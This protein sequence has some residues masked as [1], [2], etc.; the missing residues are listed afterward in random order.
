[1]KINQSKKSKFLK[2]KY[3][4]SDDEIKDFDDYKNQ[5]P[6]SSESDSNNDK[7]GNDEISKL[8][9][10]RKEME[11]LNGDDI[12]TIEDEQDEA[13]RSMKLMLK[14]GIIPDATMI[15]QARKKR[16]MARQGDYIPINSTNSVSK[17]KSRVV[18]EDDDDV[19]D[20]D[21][22]DDPD[23]LS[24]N[25]KQKVRNEKQKNRDNFLAYENGIYFLVLI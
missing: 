10:L 16:E 13:K 17:N 12:D 3:K 14:S 9:D 20:E 19:S 23:R 18:R 11:V 2:N 5:I 4:D 22:G 6:S 21:G 15:H 25:F 1:M 7:N 8:D 24:L